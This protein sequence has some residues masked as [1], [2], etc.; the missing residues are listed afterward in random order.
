MDGYYA[1]I[2]GLIWLDQMEFKQNEV[3]LQKKALAKARAKIK[4]ATV[5]CTVE[6]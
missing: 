3:I 5:G 4:A 2:I 1:Q 6:G